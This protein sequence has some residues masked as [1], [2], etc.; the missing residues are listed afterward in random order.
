MV[1]EKKPF[2]DLAPKLN[3]DLWCGVSVSL[4]FISG[5]SSSAVKCKHLS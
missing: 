2:Q 5:G 3:P 4:D 1:I